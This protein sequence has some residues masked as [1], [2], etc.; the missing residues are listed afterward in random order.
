MVRFPEVNWNEAA[1]EATALLSEFIAVD[2]SNPPGNEDAACSFLG[3]VLRREG[4]DYELYEAGPG[5][6]SLRS[7]LPGDG[8]AGPLILLNH[9]DVVPVEREFWHFEP[10]GGEVRDGYVWGRGA[11]DMKGMGIF[12]LMAVLLLKRLRLPL[13][14]DVV[15]FAMADEEMGGEYGIDWF[16]QHHPD[17]LRGDFCLNEGAYGWA[18][19][20]AVER[21]FFGY[22]PTEKNPLWLRLRAEGPPGH[23]SLPHADNALGRL[24]RALDRIQTWEQQRIIL[25]E[26]R[27]FFERLAQTG[28][29]PAV[30][31]P[32]DVAPLAAGDRM[33]NALTQHTISLTTFHSGIKTNVI[34]AQAEA[35]LD[36][37]LLP[38]QSADA[39]TRR[40]REVVDDPKVSI[41]PVM[42]SETPASRVESTVYDVAEQV[43]REYDERSLVLPVV[44]SWFTDSRGFRRAGTPAYGF[45]PVLLEQ[46][47]Y[48]SIHGH[49]ERISL[50]NVRL[51]THV[52]FELVRRLATDPSVQ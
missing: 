2:T 28:A 7:V 35:T 39:F 52:L 44:S 9:T 31:G 14:R 29:L 33:I 12:E 47:D 48:A 25:P 30:E 18:R 10:F 45:I 38:G 5:R 51:G 43:V 21:P 41:E 34:P 46:E 1:E 20:G 13:R 37:R 16:A 4:L 3:A 17:L 42:V 40:V 26:M 19:W 8:S 32:D 24:V 6:V 22:S 15:F 23:G 36:C 27:P 50:E 11:L 49:D